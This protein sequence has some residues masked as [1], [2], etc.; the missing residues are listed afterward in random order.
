MLYAF[1]SSLKVFVR[2]FFSGSGYVEPW[3]KSLFLV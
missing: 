3:N 1:V 2:L